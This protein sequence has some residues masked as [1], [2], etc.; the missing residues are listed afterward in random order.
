MPDVQPGALAMRTPEKKDSGREN[1]SLLSNVQ[2][3]AC[4]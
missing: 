2:S 4:L 3:G 1:I